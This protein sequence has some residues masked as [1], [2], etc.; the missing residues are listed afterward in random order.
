M[1]GTAKVGKLLCVERDYREDSEVMGFFVVLQDFDTG[2]EL[3]KYL[4]SHPAQRRECCFDSDDFLE[5]LISK[6]LLLKVEYDIM[7]LGSN[8][9]HINSGFYP[10]LRA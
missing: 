1:K 2:A 5:G 7:F 8:N 4:S 10:L 9:N 3:E 6:G